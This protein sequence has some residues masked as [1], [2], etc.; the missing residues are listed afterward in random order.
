VASPP[1]ALAVATGGV[2]VEDDTAAAVIS[3]VTP[4]APTVYVAQTESDLPEPV[5]ANAANFGSAQCMTMVGVITRSVRPIITRQCYISST[6]FCYILSYLTFPYL[7]LPYLSLP[8]LTL[9][10]FTLPYLT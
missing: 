9:P 5:A 1:A 2:G 6:N 4:V 8:D 7:T 3:P 10:Y